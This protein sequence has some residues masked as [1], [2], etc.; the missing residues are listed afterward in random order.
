MSIPLKESLLVPWSSNFNARIAA[1]PEA[2]GLTA[3]QAAAFA[4]LHDPF[5]AAY[6]AMMVA[7]AEGTRSESQTAA[8]D[9]AKEALI[10]YGRELYSVVQASAA[11]SDADKVLL[12]VHIPS[13]KRSP[14][15][16]PASRPR[17]NV[18]SVAAR[19]VS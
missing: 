12:G 9:D 6:E 17:V 18:V 5:V 14:I 2:F 19:R 11:V 15:P 4:A 13:G 1:T 10:A 7:R 16:A 3:A 8:K